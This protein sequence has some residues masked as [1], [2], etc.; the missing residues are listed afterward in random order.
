MQAT[1]YWVGMHLAV[2][3]RVQSRFT[4]RKKSNLNSRRS[5][6]RYGVNRVVGA[7]FRASGDRTMAIARENRQILWLRKRSLSFRAFSC[8]EKERNL[9]ASNA[10]GFSVILQIRLL[11]IPALSRLGPGFFRVLLERF[12][13]LRL[14]TTWS[15]DLDKSTPGQTRFPFLPSPPMSFNW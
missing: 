3:S 1:E 9:T 12:Q 5:G 15:A 7:A 4:N 2:L 11:Q 13:V 8:T 14:H 10:Q 6:R